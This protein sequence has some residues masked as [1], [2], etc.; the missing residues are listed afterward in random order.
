MGKKIKEALSV[1]LKYKKDLTP[2]KEA[3]LKKDVTSSLCGL[4]CPVS[5]CLKQI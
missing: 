4:L 2:K 5:F 3:H 1:P